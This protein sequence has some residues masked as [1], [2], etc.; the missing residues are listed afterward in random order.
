MSVPITLC[1]W[2]SCS[3]RT[4]KTVVLAIRK[5]LPVVFKSSDL[6]KI[7]GVKVVFM[8]HEPEWQFGFSW[9]INKRYIEVCI[10]YGFR[11]PTNARFLVVHELIHARQLIRG[12]LRV[13]RCHYSVLY[14]G[15][16][17]I[18]RNWKFIGEDGRRYKFSSVPWETDN[19][20]LYKKLFDASKT[21]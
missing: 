15:R 16:K 2:M 1:G 13:S 9:L 11:T 5:A 18:L 17:Y 14:K 10:P 12:Q 8:K 4:K 20:R 21:K 6:A 7:K 3:H 19:K